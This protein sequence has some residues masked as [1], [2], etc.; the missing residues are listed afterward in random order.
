MTTI[1]KTEDYNLFKRITGNRTINKAQVSKL[2]DSISENPD[3]IKAAPIIVNDNYEVVDGQHRL[4]ALKKLGLPVYFF[5]LPDLALS[6]VQR[7]NSAT[8]VWTPYDYAK[9]FAELGN[10]NYLIY[11]DFRKR[12]RLAH[13]ILLVYLGNKD[14]YTTHMTFRQGKFKVGDLKQAEELCGMLVEMQ[15]FVKRGDTKVFAYAFR[16][17]AMHPDY[18]H[19]R[20]LAKVEIFGN[21]FL[22]DTPFAEDYIRQLE[23]IYNFHAKSEKDKVRFF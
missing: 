12:Y 8:K 9:S 10:K 14:S 2:Y 3:L 5:K 16:K 19:K 1:Q 7:L 18:N 4:E 6:D 22:K 21:K 15:Q 20:M 11:L 23:Q 13:N 17:V